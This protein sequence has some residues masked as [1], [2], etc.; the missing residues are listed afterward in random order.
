MDRL[1]ESHVALKRTFAT[2]CYN[3]LLLQTQDFIFFFKW[4]RAKNKKNIRFDN[5]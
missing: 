3:L 4:E 1:L 2:M 5:T